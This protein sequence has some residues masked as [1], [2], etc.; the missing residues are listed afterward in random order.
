[1]SCLIFMKC[2][3]EIGLQL[4]E[5]IS[6]SAGVLPANHTRQ[7]AP[8]GHLCIIYSLLIPSRKRSF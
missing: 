5:F 3:D 1:M 4:A 6:I 8:L 7:F 2:S